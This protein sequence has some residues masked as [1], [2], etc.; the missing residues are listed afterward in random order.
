MLCSFSILIP[1]IAKIGVLV[2]KKLSFFSCCEVNGFHVSDCL[3]IG[4]LEVYVQ[5]SSGKVF[6]C[7]LLVLDL[8]LASGTLMY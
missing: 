8:C 6:D 4:D 3:F 7:R 2:L 5:L 1:Y